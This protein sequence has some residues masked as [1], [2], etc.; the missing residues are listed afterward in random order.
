MD[1][2]KKICISCSFPKHHFAIANSSLM[3]IIIYTVE[4]LKMHFPSFQ[5]NDLI[6]HCSPWRIISQSANLPWKICPQSR[7]LLC[8][9]RTYHGYNLGWCPRKKRGRSL[10][11]TIS[12]YEEWAPRA[13]TKPQQAQDLTPAGPIVTLEL[14]Y[15]KD[16]NPCRMC[17]PMFWCRTRASHFQPEEQPI[18]PSFSRPAYSSHVRRT[19]WGPP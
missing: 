9:K 11:Y 14:R 10:Q 5:V 16:N 4:K 6:L 19:E 18:V 13:D 12:A 15:T 3:F 17:P 2:I 8:S 1:W 7:F